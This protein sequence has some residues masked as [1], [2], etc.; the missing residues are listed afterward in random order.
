MGALF[1]AGEQKVRPGVYRRYE[2]AG[3]AA[4]P[5]AVYGV[6]AIPVHA[7]FGPLATVST[8]AS[9]QLS[10]LKAMYGTGGTVDAALALFDGG[11]TKVF[12]YRLG[13]GGTA[14]SLSLKAE[15]E[16]GG[17]V[18]TL[19][20]KYPTSDTYNVTI[21]PVLGDETKKQLLV[22]LDTKLIETI[23]YA[24]STDEQADFIAKVNAESKYLTASKGVATGALA[25]IANAKLTGGADPTVD[26]ESYSEALAAFEAFKWN[27]LVLDTVDV[28]VHALAQAYIDRIFN[29]GALGVCALGEP[30]TVAF[31]DRVSHAK[32]F[33]DEKIIFFGSGYEDTNGNKVDGYYAIAK[34]AGIVGSL[35]S[36]V[37]ATHTVVPGAV[38]VLETLK[39]SQYETAI[40]SGMVLLSPN[41]EGQ[42]WFD[43][44][45]NTLV[46][47]SAE[48]DEGWK[49]IRRTSTR[50]ELFDRID[51]AV[52]PLIGKVNCD[53]IGVGDIITVA[54]NVLEAMVAEKKLL[55]GASI[56][57]DT[58]Y[59]RGSD[60]AF[61]KIAVDDLDSLEKIYFRYQFRFV[62]E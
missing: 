36:N 17:V 26:N 2:N 14:A 21:K 19:T 35:A 50:F 55:P 47:L 33:N 57:E 5:G 13:T 60:Y 54:Q 6:F 3:S 41:A 23:D 12:V 28:T 43:S 29:D 11:A 32:A 48:Q 61:F 7:N 42:V 56:T 20:T 25:A 30:T 38:N 27:M 44:A 49:K 37:S 39:N 52:A 10:D 34:Q 31:A 45:V 24:A 1:R 53:N 18:A 59:R 4:V 51:R 46:T 40:T 16:S 62:A 58:E 15:G 8:F 22:Y 9:D